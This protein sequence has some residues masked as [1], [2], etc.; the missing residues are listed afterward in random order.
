MAYFWFLLSFNILTVSVFSSSKLI[1]QSE[2]TLDHGLKA[3]IG[4]YWQ[5]FS[6]WRYIA[7]LIF[8]AY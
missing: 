5:P 4:C 3:K 7:F 8:V 6:K 1:C 2:K